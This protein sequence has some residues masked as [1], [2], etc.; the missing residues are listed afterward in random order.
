[1]DKKRAVLYSGLV[2]FVFC[3]VELISG[4]ISRSLA[5]TSDAGHMFI[6]LIPLV[7]AY[8]AI[9][10]VGRKSSN[11]S[12]GYKNF[13]PLIGMIGGVVLSLFLIF[14]IGLSALQR[15]WYSSETPDVWIMFMIGLVGFVANYFAG[16][17][18]HKHKEDN[19]AIKG[20]FINNQSDKLLS[21]AV[22]VGA[23]ITKV[24]QQWFWDPILSLGMIVYLLVDPIRKLIIDTSRIL[25]VGVPV[26]LD[27][28]KIQQEILQID[29]V[30][31]IPDIHL[32][33]IGGGGWKIATL[34]ILL[35]D[36]TG[37]S[38]REVIKNQIKEVL[39]SFGINHSTIEFEDSKISCITHC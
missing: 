23:V 7:G 22:M 15:L 33:N 21:G 10:M 18:L 24:T 32:L 25:L 39:Y 30:I 11:F 12:F 38:L 9:V 19:L 29:R 3:L 34:H 2:I 36:K 27:T 4:F 37:R 28:N 20:A 13:E 14:E 6:D 26:G 31:G 1:M 5:L 16:K 17:F 8:L 35:K